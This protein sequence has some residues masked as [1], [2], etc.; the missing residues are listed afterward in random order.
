[1]SDLSL[2][3]LEKQVKL[4]ISEEDWSNAYKVCSNVLRIDPENSKFVKLKNKIEKEVRANNIRAIQIELK[5]LE[6]LRKAKKYK[7]Y[8][9]ALSPLQTYISDYPELTKIII[10]AREEYEKYIVEKNKAFIEE[11]KKEISELVKQGEFEQVKY[12]LE[13][14]IKLSPRDASLRNFA[15]QIKDEVVEQMI[16]KH[17]SL[18]ETE[19]Y[20]DILMQLLKIKAFQPENKKINDLIKKIKKFYKLYRLEHRKDF[21]YKTMEEA[22]MLKLKKKYSKSIDL[23][24]RVLEIDPNNKAAKSEYKKVIKKLLHWMKSKIENQISKNYQSFKLLSKEKPKK[25]IRI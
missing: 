8:L 2:K 22:N 6:P 12:Q 3:D 24:D 18:L 21:I 4:L 10:K 1:M 19:K 7:E 16:A 23:I 5:R 9:Q 11:K 13:Q 15:L 17:K 14:L 20:E 25:F